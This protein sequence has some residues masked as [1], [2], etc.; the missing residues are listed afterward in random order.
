MTPPDPEFFGDCL[1]QV[2]L[3]LLIG[4]CLT[5]FGVTAQIIAQLLTSAS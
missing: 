5:V 1:N 4:L 3:A 2:L